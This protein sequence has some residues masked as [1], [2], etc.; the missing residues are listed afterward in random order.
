MA[1]TDQQGSARPIS[2]RKVRLALEAGGFLLALEVSAGS[3]AWSWDLNGRSSAMPAV[4]DGTV[5]VL[6]TND[7]TLRTI[8]ESIGYLRWESTFPPQKR[9]SLTVGS[10]TV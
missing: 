4:A 2:A 3:E 7:N 6:A 8:D 10:N 9:M 1:E 5:Y